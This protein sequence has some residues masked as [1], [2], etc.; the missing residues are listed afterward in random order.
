MLG[1]PRR[2]RESAEGWGS[3]PHFSRQKKMTTKYCPRCGFDPLDPITAADRADLG[4]PDLPSRKLRE[5]D[6]LARVLAYASPK[7]KSRMRI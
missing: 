2:A 1:W 3:S 5:P 4:R 6:R 7:K